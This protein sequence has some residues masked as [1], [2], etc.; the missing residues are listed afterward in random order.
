[1]PMIPTKDLPNEGQGLKP[2]D[3]V[4]LTVK[5]VENGQ[6]EFDYPSD[7]PTPPEVPVDDVP[8]DKKPFEGKDIPTKEQADKMSVSD[9]RSKL[10]VKSE[11][12]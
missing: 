10:P 1:M 5:S 2:G 8:E 9:L 6:V 3:V 7:E 4:E 12:Y 11:E